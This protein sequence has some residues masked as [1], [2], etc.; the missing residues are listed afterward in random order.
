M[1]QMG[2]DSP[3]T[4]RLARSGPPLQHGDAERLALLHDMYPA[5]STRILRAVHC[6]DC[7]FVVAQ[8]PLHDR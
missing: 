7:G 5:C 1:L 8:C 2:P 6:S 3:D 4:L